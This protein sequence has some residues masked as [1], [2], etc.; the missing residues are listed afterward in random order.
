M[1]RTSDTSI[2]EMAL[3]GYEAKKEEIE[4]R[5]RELRTQVKGTSILAGIS[6]GQ[7]PVKRFLSEAARNRIAA[8]QRKRWAEHRKQQAERVEA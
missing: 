1:A 4:R 5:I 2:L 8:A 7:Q 6:N 3:V